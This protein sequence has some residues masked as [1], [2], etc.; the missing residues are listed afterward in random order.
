[1]IT[2]LAASDD[3]AAIAKIHVH[4]WQQAYRGLL[5]QD[6]LD[7]LNPAQRTAGWRDSIE[8]QD[9]PTTAIMVIA[10]E[11]KIHGFAHVCPTRDND[12]E[13]HPVGE[14]TSIYLRPNTWGQ[15][16]GQQLI[17][18]AIGLLT[19]AGN[20]AA[21]LWVLEENARAI[22]LYETNGWHPDGAT[23][24]A[25]IADTLSPKSDTESP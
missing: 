17:G 13:R 18:H 12:E 6:F 23:K 19:E 3:A 5:P 8:T 10:G 21:T 15:G 20:T 11:G 4:S 24:H 25:T 14:L 2:R 16:L 22:R 1:M 9:P 7:S